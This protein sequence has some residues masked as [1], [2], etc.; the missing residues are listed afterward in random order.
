MRNAAFVLAV[1]LMAGPAAAEGR[2]LGVGAEAATDLGV[3]GP[4]GN[5]L[6]IYDLEAMFFQG[7]LGFSA[8]DNQDDVV[9]IGGSFFYKLARTDASDFS[10]GGGATLVFIDQD[11]GRNPGSDLGVALDLGAKIRAFLVPNVAVHVGLGLNIL[12]NDG[13]EAFALGS[14]LAGNAGIVYFF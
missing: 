14:R 10:I 1:I 8:G 3:F 9:N 5:A 12:I 2:G 11:G 6:V 7:M 13:G 4:G